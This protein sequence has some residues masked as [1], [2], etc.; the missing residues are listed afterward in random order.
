M[1]DPSSAERV[2]PGG[3]P[4][5]APAYARVVPGSF[6]APRHYYP[7]VLNAQIHPLVRFFLSLD[8]E[9]I[10][11]RFVHL[12][13]RVDADALRTI[14]A[15]KPRYFRWAGSDL[16]HVT[17][18]DGRRQMVVVETNSCP[19]GQ[20]SMPAYDDQ[21]EQGAYRLN[22]ANGFLASVR[23]KRL[24]EG[25][26]AVIYDK[27]F[28]EA[29]GYAAALADL[30]GEHVHLVEFPDGAAEPRAWFD[31]GQ[32]LVRDES[33]TVHP[34]RCAFRYVTQRPWNRIPVQ[35]RTYILNPVLTCLAGGRNKLVAAK[36]YDLY[37]A[38][39]DAVGLRIRTPETIW[40]VAWAEIPLWV[41]RLGG[42]AVIKVPY[43]NAGQG[44][45]TIT[46]GA[47]L[48]RFLAEAPRNYERY[49]VQS[50][51]GNHSWS[52]TGPRGRL[53]HVGTVPNKRGAS[54]VA[55]VRMMVSGGPDGFRP[56]V[57]YARRASEPLL[58]TLADGVSSWDMLGTN[59]SIR[60]P[61]GSWDTDRTR[62]LLMDRKDFN[63]LGLGIDDLIE[64]YIQTVLCTLAID[65]MACNLVGS[66]G[67]L[68]MKLFRSLN[69][70]AALADE[71]M[72]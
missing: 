9:R 5:T 67:Q 38:E 37:N 53:F 52:S 15:T 35:T 17:T 41:R 45:Y 12:N 55:D 36:A 13:P 16:L 51:I 72:R 64:G 1:T 32:L 22:L 31:A 20:K 10:V 33:D 44:V 54:Y 71:I 70:D 60:D 43:S 18:A 28:M 47:E 29:S 46:S 42:H 61:D 11:R 4:P 25:G 14:L 24:P 27:N 66:K 2:D 63:A 3:A 69:D 19:S 8:N 39:L 40:D 23:G 30:T 50:L 56:L 62:L 58:D 21:D 59:L 48:D 34:V 57:I 6:D 26:L 68:K 7:R 49:I 65:K